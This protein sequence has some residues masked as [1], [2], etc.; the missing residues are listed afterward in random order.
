MVNA[1]TDGDFDYETRGHGYA[2]VRRADPR[3]AARVHAALGTA[4]SV[5]NVGAGAGSYEPRDRRVTAVEPS[6][7]MRA[8][9]PRDLAP[10]IAGTAEQLPFAD[11]SFDAG[12]AVATVHQWRDLSRG[13][14]ELRRVARGPVVILTFDPRDF[15]RLW[16]TTY[17]PELA[18]IEGRRMPAI[19]TIGAL[20]GGRTEAERV[21]VARDCT[22]GFAE[23]FYARPEAFLDPR[24][25]EAQ[26][27]WAFASPAGVRRGLDRLRADLESGAWDERFGHLRAQDEF[28][29]ALRLIVAH[30]R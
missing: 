28:D 25:R 13:L 20:L 23:A 12:M 1:P 21:P 9:R 26:S 3:I 6:A 17:F 30:P 10:A 18:V 27:W 7:V 24:V 22:D 8:Q 11:R 15:G 19:A 5:L 14:G 29:G 2:R 4:E 16:V